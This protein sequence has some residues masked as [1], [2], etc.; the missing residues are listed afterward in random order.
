MPSLDP[1][2]PTSKIAP[3]GETAMKQNLSRIARHIHGLSPSHYREHA[4]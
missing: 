2:K 1:A 3:I 4:G